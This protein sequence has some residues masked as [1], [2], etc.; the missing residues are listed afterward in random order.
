MVSYFLERKALCS[1]ASG[2]FLLGL[3]TLALHSGKTT[4]IKWVWRSMSIVQLHP[5]FPLQRLGE[6]VCHRNFN[7]A[8]L[9]VDIGSNPFMKFGSAERQWKYKLLEVLLTTARLGVEG[10]SGQF[11][12]SY[13]SVKRQDCMRFV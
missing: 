2:E 12:Q 1:A 4:I 3:S 7:V 11:R 5:D 6:A 10:Q 8:L 9:L 13:T